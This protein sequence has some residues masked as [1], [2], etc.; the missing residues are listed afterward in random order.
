MHHRSFLLA[1]AGLLAAGAAAAQGAAPLSITTRMLV[2][3]RVRAADGTTAT[4]FV[5]PA[6]VVPGTAVRI[7]IDYRNTGA[8]PLGGV[9]I[10]NAVPA[11]TAYRGPADGMPEPE[12][13]TDGVRFAPLASLRAAGG[14]RAVTPSDVT[15]VRWR[16]SAP[17]TAGAAGHLA[18]TAV[19]K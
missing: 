15:A 16:L 5:A 13:S 10:T 3:Q 12:V 1:T 7:L 11:D 18:F 19:V 4:R 8:L 14:L 9:A 2:E 17:L 6:R